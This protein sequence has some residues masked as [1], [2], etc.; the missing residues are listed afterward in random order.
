MSTRLFKSAEKQSNYDKDDD[1]SVS[2]GDRAN[3]H[4][5]DSSCDMS[6]KT[7][8]LNEEDHSGSL[9]PRPPMLNLKNNKNQSN[10]QSLISS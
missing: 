4:D 3:V 9:S 10:L 8:S 6:I 5:S 1:N 7:E 2:A